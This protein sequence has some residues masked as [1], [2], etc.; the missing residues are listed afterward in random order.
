MNC[1]MYVYVCMW[2]GMIS[3]GAGMSLLYLWLFCWDKVSQPSTSDS[4]THYADQAVF[5][6]AGLHLSEYWDLLAQCEL[7]CLACLPSLCYSLL[8]GIHACLS[9]YHV[10]E[11]LSN[12]RRDRQIPWSWSYSLLWATICAR[13]WAFRPTVRAASALPRSH[14]SSLHS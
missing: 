1:V 13:N 6:L 7:L 9:V 10:C 4:G 14:R 11:R 12:A 2:V 5:E 3:P 8:F